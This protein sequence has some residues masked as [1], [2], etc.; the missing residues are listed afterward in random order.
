MQAQQI[1][2]ERRWGEDYGGTLFLLIGMRLTT[3]KHSRLT[4]FRQAPARFDAA[5]SGV[6]HCHPRQMV[7]KKPLNL[8]DEDLVDGMSQDQKPLSCPTVMSYPLQRIRIAEIMRRWIDRN[9]LTMSYAEGLN[10]DSISNQLLS[11]FPNP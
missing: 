9:A 2:R 3:W 8:N 10:H 7:V 4:R 5:V 11:L 6:Y 1:W